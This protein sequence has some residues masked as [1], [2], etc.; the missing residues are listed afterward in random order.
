M[1]P[2]VASLTLGLAVS[3][4][5]NHPL[6]DDMTGYSTFDIVEKIRCE[7]QTSILIFESITV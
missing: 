7:A 6:V 2:F 5:T 3:G 1:R 4:C